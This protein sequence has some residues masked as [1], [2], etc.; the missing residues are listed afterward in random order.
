M[1][2][3][4]LTD[5]EAEA[6]DLISNVI[7][8]RSSI[9][10]GKPAYLLTKEFDDAKARHDRLKDT[11][12]IE[13]NS[14]EHGLLMISQHVGLNQFHRRNPRLH[15]F[16]DDVGIANDAGRELVAKLN[17]QFKADQ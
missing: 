4:E 1:A 12:G 11:A 2:H 3:I 15:S 5:A 7:I 9:D 8:D 10:L 16:L 14:Y 17:A 13:P 6:W